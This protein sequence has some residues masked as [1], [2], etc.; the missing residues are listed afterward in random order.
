MINLKYTQIKNSALMYFVY[1]KHSFTFV[2]SWDLNL[3]VF[4]RAMSYNFQFSD[5]MLW[6]L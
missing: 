1:I 6:S 5:E 2:K 4:R 3:G